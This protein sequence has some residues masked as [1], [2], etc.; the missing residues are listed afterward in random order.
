MIFYKPYVVYIRRYI[1]YETHKPFIPNL[2]MATYID[3]YEVNMPL[4]YFILLLLIAPISLNL[5]LTKSENIYT[6]LLFIVVMVALFR[7][8]YVAY[9]K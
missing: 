1:Y 6:S 2:D 3:E 5:L 8:Y 7:Y 4:L 9:H